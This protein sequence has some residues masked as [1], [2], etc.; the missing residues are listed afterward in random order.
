MWSVS[1]S[2]NKISIPASASLRAK[3]RLRLFLR[4][5]KHVGSFLS[6]VWVGV[7]GPSVG[8]AGCWV[9]VGSQTEEPFTKRWVLERTPVTCG[10]ESRCVPLTLAITGPP[11]GHVH[12]CP[13]RLLL[14]HV[15]FVGDFC[16]FQT[17]YYCN[18]QA[19][20]HNVWS[21]FWIFSPG[22]IDGFGF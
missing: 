22:L 1:E 13:T 14:C 15:S 6:C 9:G 8:G 3:T 7:S 5:S 12:R 17:D 4:W 10:V 18:S 19:D 20:I 11:A 16:D 21:F 2:A